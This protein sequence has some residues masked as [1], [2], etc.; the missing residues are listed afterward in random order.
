MYQGEHVGALQ[1]AG[2]PLRNV[3]SEI[4]HPDWE[5]ALLD[6]AGHAD[7]IVAFKGD[8][9]WMA[10]QEH[11][12][13]LTELFTITVPEQAKCAVYRTNRGATATTPPAAQ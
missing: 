10:A 2:I 5:W 8:P 13:E 4:S 9:A 11:R 12:G 1:R 7:F 3:I 6:P